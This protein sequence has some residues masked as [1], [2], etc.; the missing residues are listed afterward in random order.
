MFFCFSSANHKKNFCDRF[1][2]LNFKKKREKEKAEIKIVKT[3]KNKTKNF[4]LS[5]P[6][7][8]AM[9]AKKGLIGIC[10]RKN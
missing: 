10:A 7:S 1:K 8:H 5:K 9:I 6:L 2:I 4:K 3:V